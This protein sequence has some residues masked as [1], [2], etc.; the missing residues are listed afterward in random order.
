[1]TNLI[2]EVVD[3]RVFRN[4]IGLFATGVTV[5][6]V[7]AEGEVYGM[8]ANA[9]TSVSLEPMLV[10]VC[11]Q[12][13]AHLMSFLRQTDGFS[14]NILSEQQQNLSSYFAHM[15][16]HP[17]PP[18]FTFIPWLGGPRLEG[19]IGAIACRTR[20]FLEGGDHW[21]VVGRVIGLYRAENP[22]NPLLYYRGQYRR[23]LAGR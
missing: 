12:K 19:A 2:E 23:I 1:M 4:T 13:E 11:V 6:A 16:P 17:E 7:E 15:W 8:T 21:I 22:A 10:L 18:A 9:V 3:S 14:I 5:V 20:E